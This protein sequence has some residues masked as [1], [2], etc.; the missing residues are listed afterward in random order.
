[1]AHWHGLAKLRMHS[2]WTL[3]I[4]DKVTSAVG[5]QFRDFKAT[6]C[7]AYVTQEL[8]QEAEARTRRSAKQAAKQT[9]KHSSSVLEQRDS[10]VQSQTSLKNARRIKTFNFQTYKFHALGDYVSTIRRY[11]TT[12]SYSSEPVSPIYI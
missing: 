2:D 1:M 9:A 10:A 6:V 7:S 5:Q 3:D 11:G 8:R 4:M 12:D